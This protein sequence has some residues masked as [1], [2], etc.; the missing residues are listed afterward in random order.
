MNIKR[1]KQCAIVRPE[2]GVGWQMGIKVTDD[3]AE[4]IAR[5]DKA[6]VGM[7][8]E[9]FDEDGGMRDFIRGYVNIDSWK[10]FGDE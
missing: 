9:D 2:D 1:D 8:F 5:I 4:E 6:H 10:K 7:E 3:S